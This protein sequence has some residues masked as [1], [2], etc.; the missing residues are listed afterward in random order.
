ME[1]NLHG[2]RV[3]ITGGSQG[4]GRSIA[5]ELASEGAMVAVVARDKGKLTDL[6]KHMGENKGHLVMDLDLMTNGAIVRL[7]KI[8]IEKFWPVDIVIHNL[9]GT[10]NIRNPIGSSE[11]FGLVWKYNLGVSIDINQICLPGMQE[12]KCGRIIYISSSAAVQSNASLPYSTAKAAINA[13]VKGLSKHVAADGVVVSAV[14]PG[15]FLTEGG[16]WDIIAKNDPQFYEK[17]VTERMPI[18]RLGTP[19]EISALVTFLCS[20]R[21]S[22]FVGSIIPVDGGVIF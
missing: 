7:N 4:L 22:L 9:G 12:Q 1:L 15:P 8:L 5:L 3:L 11:E 6:L 2:K 17:Y 16:H 18:K 14:M 13:Y 19:E 10:L 20:D 21:A